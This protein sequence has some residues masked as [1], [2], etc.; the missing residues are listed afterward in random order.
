MEKIDGLSFFDY[1]SGRIVAVSHEG[2]YEFFN[3]LRDELIDA[4]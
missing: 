1:R 2:I 3:E 4:N